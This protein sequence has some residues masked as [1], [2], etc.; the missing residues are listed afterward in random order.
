MVSPLRLLIWLSPN[1]NFSS[2]E[3][4]MGLTGKLKLKPLRGI[5]LAAPGG[6]PWLVERIDPAQSV[7]TDFHERSAVTVAGDMPID[8]ALEHIKHAG[9]R[10]AIVVDSDRR[11]VL[12]MVTAYDIQGEKPIRHLQAV[13]CTHRTCSRDD[14]LVRDIMEKLED[15]QAVDMKD[16]ERAT[17]DMV[18]EALKAIGRSH[19]P[20]VE[21]SD[22]HGARLRGIFSAAKIMRIVK[23]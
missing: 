15:W 3:I 14:V 7:M 5:D 9:V 21:T 22:D 11:Q 16:V 6:D 20:V 1:H 2:G 12:G 17:V 8:T 23:D 18:L 10:S 19:L 4:D 13:G